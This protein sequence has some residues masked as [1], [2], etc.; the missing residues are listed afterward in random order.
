MCRF[1]ILLNFN[2]KPNNGPSNIL[3]DSNGNIWFNSQNGL[4][5][6]IDVPLTSAKVIDST[7]SGCELLPVVI[8]DYIDSIKV[9]RSGSAYS[10][11]ASIVITGGIGTASATPVIKAGR[12]YSVII[13]A[14]GS[15]HNKLYKIGKIEESDEYETP[16][17]NK[18]SKDLYQRLI[19]NKK[20]YLITEKEGYT[21]S[22]TFSSWNF[23]YTYDKN[24]INL[25]THAVNYLL[26]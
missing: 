3:E 9:I 2:E 13:T 14:S 11:S 1:F 15:Y 17:T 12:V 7:G 25:Y 20:T 10:A 26:S 18:F 19:K 24:I 23:D 21:Q 22:A 4:N 16:I 6:Y 5:Y 8:D